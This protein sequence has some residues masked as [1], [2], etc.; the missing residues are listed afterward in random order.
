MHTLNSKLTPIRYIELWY[1]EGDESENPI[2]TISI[3]GH[4]L[5]NR[6]TSMIWRCMDGKTSVKQ[7]YANLYERFPNVAKKQI[8]S[9]VKSILRRLHDDDLIN[10]YYHPL[11]PNRELNRIREYRERKI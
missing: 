4:F 2:T 3:T 8:Q 11:N 10:L 1:D 9:D 6:V 7:I 5:F